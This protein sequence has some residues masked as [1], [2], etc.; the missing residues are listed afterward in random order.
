MGPECR[1]AMSCL[2][3]TQK[4]VLGS[5]SRRSLIIRGDGEQSTCG[6]LASGCVFV[7]FRKENKHN[8]ALDLG[9]SLPEVQARF[10]GP[11]ASKEGRQGAPLGR[12]RA[13]P[14]R[15]GRQASGTRERTF[16]APL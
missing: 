5:R 16:W 4:T 13:E 6:T 8:T 9:G 15:R 10:F 2:G 7:K 14:W 12:G 3:W 1:A 11:E